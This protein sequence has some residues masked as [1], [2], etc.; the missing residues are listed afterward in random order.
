M[1]SSTKFFGTHFDHRK[2][3]IDGTPD[4]PI[5]QYETVADKSPKECH[6]M[7]L[8]IV[9]KYDAYIDDGWYSAEYKFS[10]HIGIDYWS[11]VISFKPIKVFSNEEPPTEDTKIIL[12]IYSTGYTVEEALEGE[13]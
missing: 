13:Y 8:K 11:Y 6:K 5:E 9:E 1:K 7:L 12:E 10:E 2:F 3:C 4:T